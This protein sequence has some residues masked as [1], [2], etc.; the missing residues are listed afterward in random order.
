MSHD[1]PA[2]DPPRPDPDLEEALASDP[3]P[4]PEKG[5]VPQ[6]QPAPRFYEALAADHVPPEGADDDTIPDGDE[7][8]MSLVGHLE[9]L[10]ARILISLASVLGAA[11]CAY[12]VSDRILGGLKN[13]APGQN[14]VFLSPTEAFFTHLSVSFYTGLLVAAPVVL[15]QLWQFLRPGL[16]QKERGVTRMLFPVVT[17]FFA[18]GASFAYGVIL[19]L[20][21]EFL[22]SF[23]T[24]DMQ[25]LLS[26]QAFT[27]FAL[28]LMLV[29]GVAFELPVALFMAG[30]M[31]LVSIE[32]IQESRPYFI[33][34]LVTVSAILT[35]PDIVTQLL[36][37][38]PIWVLFE[39]TLI[40]LRLGK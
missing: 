33:V 18:V 3:P 40:L 11:I 16:T 10:R 2:S 20:G 39:L 34:G 14:F 4:P 19:P 35:P 9:E 15:Y 30:R 22:L 27:T 13:L 12:G 29:F 6:A 31:G 24:Q 21:L 37:A 7:G 5:P 32:Q 8:R 23:A 28:T 17:L 36:L 38:A 26:I 25:A 1:P